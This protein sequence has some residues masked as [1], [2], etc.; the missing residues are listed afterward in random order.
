MNKD[1]TPIACELYS[2]YEL[3]IM[4]RDHLKL[5]YLGAGQLS[6]IETLRP[7][8]LRT[9]NKAEYLIARSL[10]GVS[11][12]LRLDRIRTFEPCKNLHPTTGA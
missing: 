7:V 11:R 10:N 9:R 4:H 8:N 6:R 3:H 5:S 2:E 12:V 1:Y